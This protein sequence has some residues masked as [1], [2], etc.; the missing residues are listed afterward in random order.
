MR[1]Q[2]SQSG[3]EISISAGGLC[4]PVATR[5][6][7]VSP[8]AKSRLIRQFQMWP[9]VSGSR[10]FRATPKQTPLLCRGG[11]GTSFAVKFPDF[12]FD[13]STPP[14][15]RRDVYLGRGPKTSE[16]WRAQP[17]RFRETGELRGCYFLSPERLSARP[18]GLPSTPNRPVSGRLRARPWA[19]AGEGVRPRAR[20]A[21]AGVIR[22]TIRPAG[23]MVPSTGLVRETRTN[24]STFSRGPDTILHP[25]LRRRFSQRQNGASKSAPEHLHGIRL[26]ISAKKSRGWCA[27]RA[28]T[29][30]TGP[31]ARRA[32][33]PSNYPW[34]QAPLLTARL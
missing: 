6:A 30:S 31:S 34:A 32:D 7:Q 21:Q 19:L 5:S 29:P 11:V 28:P 2:A 22:G 17:H 33:G 8:T 12:R 4:S 18:V 16:V 9:G 25:D 13:S 23:R 3:P 10:S 20:M 26:R 27:K 14:R 24:L 1:R 15:Q